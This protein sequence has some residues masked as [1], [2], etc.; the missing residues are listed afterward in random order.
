MPKK[1]KSQPGQ[2]VDPD[3]VVVEDEVEVSE[4][5]AN[6]MEALDEF[7]DRAEAVM[8]VRWNA[9]KKKKQYVAT[10]P[11]AQFSFDMVRDLYGGG[12]YT[13]TLTDKR[14]RMLKAQ[15]F[16][17]DDHFPW[18]DPRG[19]A[20]NGTPGTPEMGKL[21]PSLA[22][23]FGQ[24]TGHTKGLEMLVQSQ[25]AMMAALLQAIAGK[26]SDERDPLD[27]GMKIAEIIK[28]ASRGDAPSIKEM[29]GDMAETFREGIK[30]GQLA[31]APVEKGFG[32]VI[33]AL[34]PPVAKALEAAAS[35]RQINPPAD[36]PAPKP[37]LVKEAP[38]VDVS[39]APWLAHLRPFIPEITMWAKQG[40]DPEAY[41]ISLVARLPD[42]VLDEVE[43]ASRSATFIEDALGALPTPFQAFRAWLTKAL[44]ALAEQV[45]QEETE[46]EEEG[47][48]ASE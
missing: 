3:D 30:F 26:K 14:G 6:L 12:D 45:K 39:K 20:P 29:V 17:I 16:S 36:T 15:A 27:V 11:V 35:H 40:W 46:R 13:A 23:A 31:H 8:L 28:G 38:T 41:V 18:K 24:M 21:D 10:V 42:A 19:A 33:E 44:T 1:L 5:L 48:G 34:V 32:D 43:L 22:I 25:G 47:E 9:E 2:V 7:G 37:V 4:G